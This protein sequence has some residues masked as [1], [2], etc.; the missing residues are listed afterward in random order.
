MRN[1][2]ENTSESQACRAAMERLAESGWSLE[3]EDNNHALA[4][5]WMAGVDWQRDQQAR[6]HQP[7]ERGDER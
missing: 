5:M 3:D 1:Q 7:E 6:R 2:I 4:L